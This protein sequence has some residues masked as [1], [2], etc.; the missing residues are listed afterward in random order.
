MTELAVEAPDE[1][2]ANPVRRDH[3]GR[4]Y[5]KLPDS[6]REVTYT[7]TSNFAK[8]LSDQEGLTKW[9]LRNVV[10]GL[11]A[12]PQLLHGGIHPD[13]TRM[14]D[15][16]IEAAH[17]VAGGNNASR[18]GTTLHGLAELWDM[19]G[20][21]DIP[22]P[23]DLQDA[24]AAYKRITASYEVIAA[25]GFVVCDELK[26]AGSYDRILLAPDGRIVMADIKTGPDEHKRPLGVTVQC[27]IYA[28]SIHYDPRSKTR[29]VGPLEGIDQEE[30]LLIQISRDRSADRLWPLDL[31]EGWRLALK[32]RELREDRRLKLG[33]ELAPF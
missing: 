32:S 16:I 9:R 27:A 18:W 21:D 4:P 7:R 30:G 33:P 11:L 6:D 15:S 22:A 19:Y 14:V 20:V 13:N 29:H 10:R 24:L 23:P 3:V 8:T 17:E 1:V 25:E 5:I 2:E 31:K 26:C 12:Q 28:H